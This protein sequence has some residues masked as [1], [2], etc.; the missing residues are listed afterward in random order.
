MQNSLEVL[1]SRWCGNITGIMQ[2]CIMQLKAILSCSL[3][4]DLKVASASL[5]AIYSASIENTSHSFIWFKCW[6]TLSVST[7]MFDYI[8]IWKEIAV[9]ITQWVYNNKRK[10]GLNEYCSCFW[11]RY[12]ITVRAILFYTFHFLPLVVSLAVY[13]VLSNG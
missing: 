7:N 10:K 11:S 9:C 13:M 12:R 8:C 3:K 6:A 2:L 4:Q 1:T 5:C